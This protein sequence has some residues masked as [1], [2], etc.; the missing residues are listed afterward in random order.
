MKNAFGILLI[1]AAFS[2]SCTTGSDFDDV[3]DGIKC[4]G[5][6]SCLDIDG[7]PVCDCDEG[8]AADGLNCVA[9]ACVGYCLHGECS[10]NLTGDAVC[11]CDEGYDG[12]RCDE[13]ADGYVADGL[14]CRLEGSNSGV[15]KDYDCGEGVC[16]ENEDDQAECGCNTGYDGERCD[17]CADGYTLQDGVCLPEGDGDIDGDDDADSDDI[18]GD[19]ESEIDGDAGDPCNPNP[20]SERFK[21]DCVAD[22]S[23]FVC[24]C[25]DGFEDMGGICRPECLEGS[26]FCGL[27]HESSSFMVSANGFGA[28]I[29]DKAEK[30]ANVLLEHIYRNWDD[31]VWTHNVLFDTYFGIS[32]GATRKWLNEVTPE[33]VG[34]YHETGIIHIVRQIDDLRVESFI[35]APWQVD[36]PALTMISKVTNTGTQQADLSVY[37]LHNY[38]LGNA[39]DNENPKYLDASG[40]SMSYINGY[41]EKG[42]AG[43]LYHRPLGD[44]FASDC[45]PNNPYQALKDGVDL[46][47]NQESAAGDDRVAGYQKKLSLAQGENGWFGVS[48]AF[49]AGAANGDALISS[50]GAAYGQDTPEQI[51][52]DAL[53]EWENWRKDPIEGLSAAELFV[54]RQSEAVLRMGQVWE[55]ADLSKGQILASMPPGNWNICWMRDMSY[56]IAALIKSGHYTEAKAALKFVLDADSGYYE[57]EAG[58]PYQVTITR[59]FGRGKEETDFN[60]YGPNIEFDGFGQ[61]LW[62]LYEYVEASGDDSLLTDY[63]TLIKDKIADALLGLMNPANDLIKADSSIWE[64]HWDGMQKQFSYTSITASQGLCAYSKIVDSGAQAYSDA[65]VAI[66]EALVNHLL[67]GQSVLASSLEELNAASGYH[68]MA[69]VEAFNWLQIDPT[70]TVADATFNMYLNELSVDHGKGFFR[71]DD[72][73]WYDSQ[74]WVFVDLRA[75]IGARLAGRA[76][77]ADDLLHWITAQAINNQGMIAELHHPTNADYEGEAPM[78]GFGAGAYILALYERHD[79]RT[80]AP[81][82]G[83]WE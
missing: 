34:Y 51:L 23:A 19:D 64:V 4:S 27:A 43:A 14:E 13:C 7:K 62:V 72:G 57:T 47:N 32:N 44:F 48:S 75:S 52:Q 78:V 20:C 31:G 16:F 46:S 56:A 11:E 63:G 5:H 45:T 74:E 79:P 35:F 18:D 10:L 37:S 30:K 8:Y 41:I 17:E 82:C 6:G 77:L 39:T 42:P 71:N 61:F 65:A 53:D 15:C 80:V 12:Q 59:Y 81:F 25:E 21:G 60:E 69:T 54:Y 83:S 24:Q 29:Y 76:D 28:V 38:H 50:L 70:G 49:D 40:E 55:T 3:C 33:Y 2:L 58:V 36:L 66:R 68:D 73:G 67:D 1:L 22:G 9:Q 26:E